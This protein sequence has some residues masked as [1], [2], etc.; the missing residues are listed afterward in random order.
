[1]GSLAAALA[2]A[3]VMAG[4]A[5]FL[6]LRAVRRARAV[7]AEI[8]AALASGK[9]LLY[10]NASSLALN[11]EDVSGLRQIRARGERGIL[12][13]PGEYDSVGT[14]AI[15]DDEGK[16]IAT[17]ADAELSFTLKAGRE[18][19]VGVYLFDSGILSTAV[20]HRQLG[21]SGSGQGMLALACVAC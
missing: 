10:F 8:A 20:A 4:A 5:A 19:E 11:G 15:R 17:F 7:R 16:L 14:Y 12:T 13:E 6:Y 9:C 1:M 3:I 18:Y 21:P 2:A